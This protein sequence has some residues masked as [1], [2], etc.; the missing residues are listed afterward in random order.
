MER[1]KGVI[2][3]QKKMSN[4]KNLLKWIL[5]RLM[6]FHQWMKIVPEEWKVCCFSSLALIIFWY[7][8]SVSYICF[9]LLSYTKEI[10]FILWEIRLWKFFKIVGWFSYTSTQLLKLTLYDPIRMLYDE[11]GL[12]VLGS[13]NAGSRDGYIHYL[14][15]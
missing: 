4:W 2:M 15:K 11:G 6:R 1:A 13:T 7:I 14:C 12:S 10:I 8:I 5:K 9:P 3:Y